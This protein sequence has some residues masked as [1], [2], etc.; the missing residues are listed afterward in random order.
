M[1]HAEH[2][3]YPG[4]AAPHNNSA[5][6]FALGGEY[7]AAAEQVRRIGDVVTELPWAYLDRDDPGTPFAQRREKVT[8]GWG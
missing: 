4:G 2:G 6:C 8:G 5:M 7:A 3:R 1:R